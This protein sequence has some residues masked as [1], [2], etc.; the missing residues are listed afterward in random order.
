[1][2]FFMG[3]DELGDWFGYLI[4]VLGIILAFIFFFKSR[5]IKKPFFAVN[6]PTLVAARLQGEHNLKIVWKEHEL[7][8]VYLVKIAFW[9]GGNDFISKDDMLSA[10]SIKSD[11]AQILNTYIDKKSREDLQLHIENKNN[12]ILID[13]D[14]NEVLE[15]KDGALISILYSGSEESDWAVYGRIKGVPSGFSSIKW[16]MLGVNKS[17]KSFN[18]G[19]GL[20]MLSML[21]LA[22]SVFVSENYF[23]DS[24][25]VIFESFQ[26]FASGLFIG[27]LIASINTVKS[28]YKSWYSPDWI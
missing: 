18:V 15:S 23:A 8:M 28:N 27:I 6:Q 25:A 4:G 11:G 14:G 26:S 22:I 12:E 16:K 19:I 7:D 21:I 24:K 1:M 20:M 2:I 13:I 10:I 5:K 9:N 17:R 3:S